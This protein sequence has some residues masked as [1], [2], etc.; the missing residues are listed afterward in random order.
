MAAKDKEM[1]YKI[2]ATGFPSAIKV[3]QTVKEA[4]DW[5]ASLPNLVEVEM[6]EVQDGCDA[7]AD[8]RV[9]FTIKGL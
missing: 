3:F 7:L 1:T 4:Y 2:Y 9:Y 5:M 8:G 6:D